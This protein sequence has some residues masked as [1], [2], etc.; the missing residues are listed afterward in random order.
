MSY[1]HE[2]YGANE[3]TENNA[4]VPKKDRK[5]R[6]V[7][8]AKQKAFNAKAV[9]ITVMA[10]ILVISLSV[11]QLNG[12]LVG[13]T[14]AD[15]IA[16]EAELASLEAQRA[17]KQIKVREEVIAGIEAARAKKEADRVAAE[18]EAARIE[19]ERVEAERLEAE[20]LQAEALARATTTTT[21]AP[22]P[23]SAPAPPVPSVPDDS[24]WDRLAWCESRGN[25]A[26]NSGNGFYGG[27]QF[28]LSTWLN[29]GGG[30]YAYYPHEATREQQIEVASRLQAQYG[31]GQWPACS[32]M[33]GLR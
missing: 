16:V 29:M 28:M 23:V 4:E 27:I 10:A 7:S 9:H 25:W 22:A 5:K 15:Q 3:L 31:W 20:R 6:P 14:G 21:Q 24:V 33:L 30:Q 12:L 1:H 8:S 17:M 19:A 11:I 13:S 32:S 2:T 26:M 18:Q